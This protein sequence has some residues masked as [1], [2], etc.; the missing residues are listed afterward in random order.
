[1]EPIEG[2]AFLTVEDY[3]RIPDDGKRH[4]LQAGLLIAEPQPFPRH[5]QVQARLAQLLLEFVDAHDLGVVL[6][7]AGFLLSRNPDTVRGPDVAFVRAGRFDADEAAREYFR[8]APD[9]A[10]EILSPSNRAGDTH[11]KVAD[12][13]A[14]GASLVWVIDPAQRIAI[15][16]R[17][18]LA[19]RRI[20]AE[21]VLDGEDV[22][23]G[24]SAPLGRILDR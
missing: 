17:S 2:P 24:F 1:M 15:I 10:I 20:G 3:L 19:P 23:P 8:G 5:G 6:T 9:L 16:Y 22:L 21:G 12:Y 11:A 7:E 13:L 4:S 14:A 18:L